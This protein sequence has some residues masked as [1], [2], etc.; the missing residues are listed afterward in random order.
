MG[1]HIK[2]VILGLYVFVLLNFLMWSIIWS[3]S[4]VF[5]ADMISPYEAFIRI[6]NALRLFLY[7][8]GLFLSMQ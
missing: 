3:C 1:K 6:D 8:I 5:F 7:I 2:S 4:M